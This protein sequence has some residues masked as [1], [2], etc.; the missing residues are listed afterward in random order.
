MGAEEFSRITP[1][2]DSAWLLVEEDFNLAREHELES[3][4][5]IGNGYVGSRGSLH[6]G[7]SLSAPAT[8][9][10][11][12][13]DVDPRGS[14]PELAVAPDWVQHRVFVAHDESALDS[15]GVLS[16]RRILDMRQG[17]LWRDWR[18]RDAAGRVT[19]LRSLRLAS[20]ADPHLLFQSVE[21]RPENYAETLRVDTAITPAVAPQGLA[22]RISAERVPVQ[23]RD[24][25]QLLELQTGTGTRIAVS[26]INRAAM[27]NNGAIVP[28]AS[29]DLALPWD[30]KVNIGNTYR[31]DRIVAI[32]TSRDV[33]EPS[34]AAIQRVDQAS[35]AHEDALI[36]AHIRAWERRWRIADVRIEGDVQAQR[37]LR[38]AGYHLISAAS[39]EDQRV[40]VGARALTGAAYKGHVFWDTDIFMLPFYVFTHPMSARTL[41]MYRYHTLPGARA[42]AAAYGYRGALFAWESTDT[43]EETTPPYA[44]A[45]NGEVLQIQSGEQEHHISADV[46]YAVW[47]YWRASADDDF[48][49]EAGAEIVLET[50]RFWASR[51]EFGEDEHYHIRTVI[52]PDEYH[53]AVD[54]NAY[55]N[56]LAQWNLERGVETAAFV[57]RRWPEAW[58]SLV[59]RLALSDREI[60][61]W[62]EIARRMYLG[63][64]ASTGLVE[65]FTGY[66]GL[67]HI[68]LDA[69]PV[70]TGALDLL[71][72]RE[73]VS[74]SQI[75]KQADVVMLI[76]L[77]WDRF[78]PAQR[79]ANFLYYATRTA[80]GSSLS[81]AIYALVATRLGHV[82]MGTMYFRQAAE[83]DLANN[84][85]NAAGGVHAAALGG[86]WQA[87]VFGFAGLYVDGEQVRVA[88]TAEIAWR[89][90][91]L[92][93]C[94]HG[95][96]L[97]L[98]V[99]R[100]QIDAALEEGGPAPVAVGSGPLRMI[101]SGETVRW[102]RD[103][104][105]EWREVVDDQR[106]NQAR[107]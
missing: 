31:F 18:V 21:L 88:P 85:G 49:R 15:G 97:R 56:W 68:D 47:Q 14:V 3:L 66:F 107:A 2:R 84:M 29:Q 89:S 79:E 38:F 102:R 95:H 71:L 9:I 51:G 75:V 76:Y 65:Q 96:L 24:N 36:E 5:A 105:G 92:A 35:I 28:I 58:G 43:G 67:E 25:V 42:K 39:W 80:H 99:A 17:I 54:D 94:W 91:A 57:A 48:F 103:E 12:V 63:L 13:F 1:T 86:L 41:L 104:H 30:V 62:R 6:E 73:R 4:F 44:L 37:A 32:Y 55:T 8:F 77:L 90:I 82:D 69:L 34:K 101:G 7:T 98:N 60:A 78:T 100:D 83:V 64:D 10:A 59:R 87:A 72:G 20:L 45:P 23:R 106:S 26:A 74:R 19:D 81:P 33:P 53:E 52:G 46:A 22:L 16:Q 40:S 11:G 70:R 61:E 27:R 50:A 93:L